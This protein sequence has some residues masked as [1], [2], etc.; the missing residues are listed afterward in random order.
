MVKKLQFLQQNF[1]FYYEMMENHTHH[2]DENHRNKF[3]YEGTIYTHMS[4]VLMQA[5]R[6]KCGEILEWIAIL[7][8]VAKPFSR[9]VNHSMKKVRFVGHEGV[10]FYIAIEIL[11]KIDTLSMADKI[12]ILKV[13]SLHGTVMAYIPRSGKLDDK[14]FKAYKNDVDTLINLVLHV[15]NDVFG[16]F[17]AEPES[18]EFYNLVINL[19]SI[20]HK[21]KYKIIKETFIKQPNKVIFPISPVL[22]DIEMFKELSENHG[23]IIVKTEEDLFA[24]LSTKRDIIV[25]STNLSYK[26]RRNLTR[27]IY[28]GYNCHA[29]VFLRPFDTMLNPKDWN[30]EENL[31]IIASLKKF[32]VPSY[33]EGFDIID[34][35][36]YDEILDDGLDR[37]MG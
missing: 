27:H 8:D 17:P 18:K 12:T 4:M 19:P 9:D 6:F 23:S 5:K 14:I 16:R 35:A 33:F 29:V 25:D 26:Q 13:I 20:I 28:N 15:R 32:V 2:Y 34:Y 10:S 31:A 7:H 37:L 3:H 22:E 36:Q 11:N 24:A 1:P 21:N 30:T